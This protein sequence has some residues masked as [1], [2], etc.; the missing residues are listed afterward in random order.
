MELDQILKTSF[1]QTLLCG[2]RRYLLFQQDQSL[3]HPA[4]IADRLE[5]LCTTN[6]VQ[7]AEMVSSPHSAIIAV[8]DELRGRLIS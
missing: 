7:I 4:N 2:T 1:P 5:E 6:D 8:L 3:S